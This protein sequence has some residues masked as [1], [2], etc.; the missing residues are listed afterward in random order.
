MA[1]GGQQREGGGGEDA[2]EPPVTP[3][4]RRGRKGRSIYRGVCV[5][6]EGKWRAVIYMERK[7]VVRFFFCVGRG[8]RCVRE[9]GAGKGAQGGN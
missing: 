3:R 8:R 7:Q 1:G 4:R 2:L 6:R 9:G 5:T